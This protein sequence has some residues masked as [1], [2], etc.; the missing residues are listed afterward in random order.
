MKCPHQ[1]ESV[2]DLSILTGYGQQPIALRYG[3]GACP[4]ASWNPLRPVIAATLLI[5]E[6]IAIPIRDIAVILLCV[7][8]AT[9]VNSDSA[10]L[11]VDPSQDGPLH[12]GDNDF[13]AT[14]KISI[15]KRE[16]QN[17]LDGPP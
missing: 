13:S 16:P 17:L 15:L 12:M 10:Q 5:Q 11:V 3:R 6:R 7:Y 9:G 8:A 1:K 14:T 2:A 4:L